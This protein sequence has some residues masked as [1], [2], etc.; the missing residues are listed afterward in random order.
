MITYH[1]TDGESYKSIMNDGCVM[2]KRLPNV[3]LF[4]DSGDAESYR[5]LMGLDM[6]IMCSIT[7][8]Q[9]KSRW[10]PKY[11]PKGVIKLIEGD[12]AFAVQS[13]K[14]NIKENTTKIAGEILNT[15]LDKLA[16]GKTGGKVMMT[17]DDLKCVKKAISIVMSKFV[18]STGVKDLEILNDYNSDLLFTIYHM[19]DC[20]TNYLEGNEMAKMVDVDKVKE[21]IKDYFAGIR[22]DIF[23]GLDELAYGRTWECLNCGKPI[24]FGDVFGGK[25]YIH[26]EHNGVRCDGKSGYMYMRDIAIP[27]PTERKV[28]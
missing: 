22:K 24:Y 15:H 21:I 14:Y 17:E 18:N 10:K 5:E 7:N 23:A 6:I 20:E 27:K 16:Y 26:T 28:K 2:P 9:I 12:T 13:P 4:V 19:S 3:Y 11:A 25:Y 1:V 8:N